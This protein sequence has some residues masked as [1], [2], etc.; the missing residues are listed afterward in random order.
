VGWRGSSTIALQVPLDQVEVYSGVMAHKDAF[1]VGQDEGRKLLW[2]LHDE[3][4]LSW[5]VADIIR[6]GRPSLCIPLLR[7]IRFHE[8]LLAAKKLTLSTA[9]SS[10]SVVRRYDVEVAEKHV[11]LVV[12]RLVLL[13]ISSS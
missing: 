11:G 13:P 2:S 6:R 7:Q 4:I 5:R 12:Q 9:A 1:P 3:T 8:P 10:S